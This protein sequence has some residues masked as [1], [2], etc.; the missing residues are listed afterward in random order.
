MGGRAPVQLRPARKARPPAGMKPSSDAPESAVFR[1]PVLQ[2]L[3]YT[4]RPRRAAPVRRSPQ[5]Q[6]PCIVMWPHELDGQYVPNFRS[7][8]R[9]PSAGYGDYAGAADIGVAP[10][11]ASG[12]PP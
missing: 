4:Y 7:R 3:N 11:R 8:A 9:R 6:F 1:L 10:V 5:P 12:A 2:N